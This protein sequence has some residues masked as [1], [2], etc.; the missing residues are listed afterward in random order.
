[1]NLNSCF[2]FKPQSQ[3]RILHV[4]VKSGLLPILHLNSLIIKCFLLAVRRKEKT[5]LRKSRLHKD[6]STIF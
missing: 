5:K 1:M 2:P 3:V 4:N 6:N